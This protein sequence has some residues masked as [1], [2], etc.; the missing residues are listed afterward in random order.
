MRPTLKD[1]CREALV[2]EATVS[3]VINGSPLV[4]ERTRA[5][6]QEVI[7]R[8]GY[9]PN[10]AARNLSRSKTDTIG[11]VF[12]RLDIAEDIVHEYYHAEMGEKLK[13]RF[14]K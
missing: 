13:I 6:V 1:V 5:R 8:L 14:K 7:R 12:Q 4:H 10:A 9:T 3:R 2:S 11:V